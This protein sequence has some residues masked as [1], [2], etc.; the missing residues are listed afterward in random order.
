[1]ADF[2]VLNVD[3]Y[4]SSSLQLNDEERSNLF[5]VLEN[6]F[7]CILS[8]ESRERDDSF[9]QKY[10]WAGEGGFALLKAEPKNATIALRVA[11]LFATYGRKLVKEH[12]PKAANLR[13]RICIGKA[14]AFVPVSARL[15]NAAGWQL[16]LILK[17]EREFGTEDHISVWDELFAQLD[18]ATQKRFAKGNIVKGRQIYT[19]PFSTP[20]D[21][22]SLVLA[23]KQDID[24]WTVDSLVNVID[25]LEAS[26]TIAAHD[27]LES[28][29]STSRR[30]ER[31]VMHVNQVLETTTP[32]K[33]RTA[34]ARKKGDALVVDRGQSARRGADDF[35]RP[36]PL[37][38]GKKYTAAIAFE[39]QVPVP[40]A[41]TQRE[42]EKPEEERVFNLLHEQQ[43]TDELASLLCLPVTSMRRKNRTSHGVLCIDTN[44]DD[45]FVDA[46]W[47]PLFHSLEQLL[48]ELSLAERVSELLQ[49]L[50]VHKAVTPVQG[51]KHVE[52]SQQ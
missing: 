51:E 7:A 17:Y 23:A 40:V 9:T 14:S 37:T 28:V 21:L 8:N 46:T 47:K 4:K 19:T 22:T 39:K 31:V 48:T 20:V 3:V 38:G 36:I 13:F 41:S 29:F 43:R 34:Y 18:S 25:R 2:W 16:S 24:L 10:L 49:H 44:V 52:H 32:H 12:L 45:F 27:L 1:M 15:S 30:M 11:D 33:F 42:L 35:R 6:L 50:T 26:E 5:E